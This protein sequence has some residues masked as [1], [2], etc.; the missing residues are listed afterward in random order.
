MKKATGWNVILVLIL[1]F[2]GAACQEKTPPPPPT[3][4]PPAPT[5][6]NV[7]ISSEGSFDP[8]DIAPN[9]NDTVAFLANTDVVLCLDTDAVFGDTRYPIASGTTE[10]LV[11]LSGA[12]HVD[13]AYIAVLGDD[14][15]TCDGTKGGEGGGKT[16]PP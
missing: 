12:E 2:V 1:L 11:V 4:S 14:T 6:I 7:T 13:F 10:S 16:G 9:P 3:P 15:T 5:T 8:I